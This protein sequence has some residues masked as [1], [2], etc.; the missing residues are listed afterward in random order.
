MARAP[1]P[2]FRCRSCQASHPKW[3][4]RCPACHGWN[5]LVEARP[6][7]PPGL[8]GLG[9][10]HHAGPPCPIGAVPAAE[11][12]ALAS[13]VAELDRVLGGGLVPGSVT[14]LGGEPGIGKST[15]VLQAL[16]GLARRGH[17]GLLVTGEESR[18]QVRARAERVG[19]LEGDLWLV[20]ETSLPT[21]LARVEEV[22]PAV[23]AIDSIQ[24]VHDPAFE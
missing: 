23:L 16:A 2:S 7:G 8:A 21:V 14:L 4:G 24:T 17:R 3:V 20:A 12:V 6:L 18:Q 13:G 1:R 19:A 9:G 5:T 10:G 15:L 22:R 11:Q